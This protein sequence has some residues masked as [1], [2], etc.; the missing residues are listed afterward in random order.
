MNRLP[1]LVLALITPVVA[2]LMLGNPPLGQIWL[3][4]FWVPIYGAGTVLIRELV[5]RSGRGWGAILLLG[6]A[7]GIVEEG[8]ALQALSSPTL[9]GVAGWAPRVLGLNSAYT[10]LNLVYH[11]V[12]S[13]ALPILL[14]ELLFPRQGTRPYLGKVGLACAGVVFVLGAGVLRAMTALFMDPGYTM[15]L[16]VLL[17]CLLA[18]VLLAVAAFTAKAGNILTKP[19]PSPWVVGVV[20][21][22]AAFGY[23]ALLFPFGGAE[24]PAFTSGAWVWLPMGAAAVLAVAAGLLVRR[25]AGAHGLALVI[26]AL[27]AHSLFGVVA[28]A[29][30]L[31]DRIWL[32]ALCAV[33]V[34]ATT[35]RRRALN[36]GAAATSAPT[37]ARPS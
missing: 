35:M 1:A 7:Y 12:F 4:V 2:E 25:W 10:E 14:V 6:V 11:A 15:P 19:S 17:G 37:P 22:V 28:N 31:L 24:H 32:V 33:T 21:F 18:I 27:I 26:G 34:G 9:Y 20:A 29:A 3:M 23:M 8:L 5:R 16:P 36:R 13:V 30:T